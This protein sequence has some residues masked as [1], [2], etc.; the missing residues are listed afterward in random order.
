MFLKSTIGIL[1]LGCATVTGQDLTIAPVVYEMDGWYITSFLDENDTVSSLLITRSVP[2]PDPEE[3]VTGVLATRTGTMWQ[4]R[5]WIG[6]STESI[7]VW[8]HDELELPDPYHPDQPWPIDGLDLTEPAFV[9]TEPVPFGKGIIASHP[10]AEAVATMEDPAPLL[11]LL[12]IASQPAAN[13]SITAGGATNGGSTQPSD[14]PS[15]ICP[16]RSAEQYW[17]AIATSVESYLINPETINDVF[18]STIDPLPPGVTRACC[19]PRRIILGP[20]AW[21]PWSCTAPWS[22]EIVSVSPDGCLVTVRYRQTATRNR[23]RICSYVHLNCSITGPVTQT[24]TESAR[25]CTSWPFDLSGETPPCTGRAFVPPATPP[26]EP[27]CAPNPTCG[28]PSTGD[29]SPSCP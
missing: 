26:F 29:W 14:P 27:P 4:A 25:V 3:N 23:T 5:A 21:T 9:A 6:Q 12:E 10:L 11:G 28:T 7:L 8:M 13:G 17:N 2:A 15:S 22:L 24:Q 18:D 16:L 20:T 1:A 19:R